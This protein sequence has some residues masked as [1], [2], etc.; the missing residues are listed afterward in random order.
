MSNYEKFVDVMTSVVDIADFEDVVK[1]LE[2]ES[3]TVT[4]KVNRML[5][6]KVFREYLKRLSTDKKCP[7]CGKTLYLSD[8]EDYSYMCTECQENYY[9]IEVE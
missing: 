7:K 4:A 3:D 2:D 8:I 9:D 6:A 5:M 1:A